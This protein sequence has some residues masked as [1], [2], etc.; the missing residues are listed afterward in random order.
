MSLWV[1]PKPQTL[2]G[3]PIIEAHSTLKRDP[4]P[5]L[6]SPM[7]LLSILSSLPFRTLLDPLKEPFKEPYLLSPMSL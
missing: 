7:S 2:K 5:Y 1:D 6:L 4:K 3:S